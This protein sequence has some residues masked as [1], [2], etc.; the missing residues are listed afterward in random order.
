MS[1]P[2]D[3]LGRYRLIRRLAAGGMG[4]V[5]LAEVE[6][7]A[8][9]TKRVAIKRILPH[10]AEDSGFVRKFIDEAHLMVQLHHGNIVP[11]LELADDGGELYI[12][13]EYLPGRDLKTVI[14]RQ[15]ADRAQM[16]VDL[17]VWLVGEVLAGLDY[18]H[19]KRGPDGELLGVVHRDVSP[20]NVCLGAGGEVKLV[21]FGIARARG[22]LHQSISG[23]L[24][25]KFVY[26]SPEQADGR[27]VD[28]RS[29]V[30][31][32][33]LVLYELLTDSRPFEGD[34]ETET[35]RRVRQCV[36]EPPSTLRAEVSPALDAI[37]MKA[38]AADPDDRY[39]TAA[40]MRRALAHHLA[41]SGSEADAESLSHHLAAIF[42]EGVVPKA[43]PA[44]RSFDDALLMQLGTG[45]ASSD[46]TR[47]ASAPAGGAAGALAAIGGTRT[48][49]PFAR[50]AG[51]NRSA[52]SGSGTPRRR[53]GDRVDEGVSRPEGHGYTPAAG[54]PPQSGAHAAVSD[55]H[56]AVSGSHPAFSDS[57][58]IPPSAGHPVAELRP[59]LLSG[60][61]PA[62]APRSGGRRRW[63]VLGL[64]LG[65]GLAAALTLWPRGAR[66]DPIV[67]PAGLDAVIEVD[68]ARLGDGTRLQAGRTYKVC[69]TAPGHAPDCRQ[70]TLAAGANQPRLRP[71]PRPTLDPVI[72]PAAMR[73]VARVLLEGV[74]VERLPFVVE[75]G[76]TYK[77]CVEADGHRPACQMLTAEDGVNAPR[78]V[79]EPLPDAGAVDAG[80]RAAAPPDAGVPDAAPARTPVRPPTR[81]RVRHATLT[82]DVPARI[83]KGGELLGPTP[84][85]VRVGPR[86]VTYTLEADGRMSA[87]RTIPANHRGGT[88]KVELP[89][90][91]YLTL[92]A[93]PAASEIVLDGK[94]VGVGVLTRF[95]VAPGAHTL[96]IRHAYDGRSG[97]YGPERIRLEPGEE[98]NLKQIRVPLGGAGGPR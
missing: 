49:T 45:S 94:V 12:V 5:Y 76:R 70:I 74:A 29:D 30:F 53:A 71:A 83:Y 95:R 91:A 98:L 85:R 72:E 7:A 28:A 1:T 18:A 47:T 33:G 17:A 59:D 65:L 88:V 34:T 37:V 31:S 81:P 20:S 4:E 82:S 41:V 61:H 13:M 93:V 64:L 80:L 50:T 90:P 23:T 10:L 43:E 69:A 15:R 63:V 22:G 24:Q 75:P 67:E 60:G 96:L 35:L 8:N 25:G 51:S 27:A 78:F 55:S 66:L 2:T 11:V 32:A 89:L 52:P 44:P 58:R 84:Q 3:R 19:R 36:V 92:R 54:Y 39:A 73:S 26:M 86:A 9:F 87:R 40:E 21:D 6:G 46:G 48:P 42:V 68:G 57:H 62:A 14:R 79:L 77:V 97:Q 16:P 56:P 38:L